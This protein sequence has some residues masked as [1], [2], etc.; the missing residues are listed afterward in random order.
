LQTITRIFR[1]CFKLNG[2]NTQKAYFES[3]K[4]FINGAQTFA[5]VFYDPDNAAPED[6]FRDSSQPEFRGIF[7][8]N[9]LGRRARMP[10]G[11]ALK[12]GP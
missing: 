12:K 1:K 5:P 8:T 10:V 4:P 7:Q 3:T 6:S 9:S 2:V 11:K